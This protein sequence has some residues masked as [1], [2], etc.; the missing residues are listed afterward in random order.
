MKIGRNAPCP[1]GSGKKYKKCCENKLHME[2]VKDKAV[3]YMNQGRFEDAEQVLTQLFN[4]YDDAMLRNNLA[5]TFLEK[6][7]P[8]RCLEILEPCLDPHRMDLMANPFTFALAARAHAVLGRREEAYKYLHQAETTFEDGLWI[9]G[10]KKRGEDEELHSWRE[11]T[12]AIMKAAAELRDHKRVLRIFNRWENEH[13]GWENFFMA[14]AAYFNLKDFRSAGYTW[15]ELSAEWPMA[16]EFRK[17]S[18]LVDKGVIPP[19]TLD[20]SLIK[21]NEFSQIMTEVDKEERKIKEAMRDTSL[22]LILLGLAFNEEISQEHNDQL[23]RMMVCWGEEWGEKLGKGILDA[24]DVSPG[25]KMAAL[26]GL[27]E[28]GV[29]RFDEPVP[30]YIDGEQRDVKLQ[31]FTLVQE[32]DDDLFNAI[33]KAKEL[34]EEDRLEE[35]ISVLEKVIDGGTFF[36]PAAVD[37]ANL[38]RDVDRLEEAERYLRMAEKFAPQ[39][40]AVLFNLAGLC[41]EKGDLEQ[42]KQYLDKIDLEEVHEELRGK[43]DILKDYIMRAEIS[44]WFSQSLLKWKRYEEERRKKIEEK[45]L[46]VNPSLARCLKNMPAEWLKGICVSFGFKPA[47]RREEREQQILHVLPQQGKLTKVFEESVEQEERELLR[48]LLEKGGW[49]RLSEVTRKYGS[50]EGDGFFWESHL[51]ESTVGAL[52]A[53]G[54][55]GIGRTK[56]GKRREKIITIPEE[57]RQPLSQLLEADAQ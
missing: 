47:R 31:E 19:F 3:D 26:R 32:P 37:L 30:M 20:Y 14:G 2:E 24:A 46:S 13:V 44:D 48:Y 10:K 11:Y 34:R 43:V 45:T 53:L 27:V 57:L 17:I 25:L 52:W 54:L 7:E 29:Y 21:N 36:L 6:G 15:D 56:L 18:F 51:P 28:K 4:K 41:L 35:A 40:P 38:L 33:D 8:V 42:S 5:L 50:M 1:C 23:L 9:L 22:L 12:V 55:V 16:A 49:S 39:E